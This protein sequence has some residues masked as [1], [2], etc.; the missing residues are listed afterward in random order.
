[1]KKPS[2][3]LRRL[4]NS[5]TLSRGLAGLVVALALSFDMSVLAWLIIFLGGISDLVDGWLAR[6]AGGGSRLGALLD[7]LTD[8]ILMLA[9]IIWLASREVLPI[10]A[11]WILLTREIVISG[12]RS[13]DSKGGP[14]SLAGKSKTSLQYL[15]ILFML[16]PNTWPQVADSIPIQEIGWWLFWPSLF[17]ALG[18]AFKYLKGTSV[19]DLN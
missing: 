13:N 17:F 8:K 2:T 14:A 12:W 18:S 10:W 9:P 15:S 7:P 4:A 5:L 11:V 19:S 1:M 16:W 3:N 6:Q